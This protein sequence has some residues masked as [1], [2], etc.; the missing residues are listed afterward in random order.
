MFSEG[1]GFTAADTTPFRGNCRAQWKIRQKIPKLDPQFFIGRG[2]FVS[3]IGQAFQ[4]FNELS[5]GLRDTVQAKTPVVRS[6]WNFF[7]QLRASDL[8]HRPSL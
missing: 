6:K 4:R 8:K 1:T 5:S 7:Y 2:F 3:L